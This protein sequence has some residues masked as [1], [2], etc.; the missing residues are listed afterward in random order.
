MQNLKG[1]PIGVD[2]KVNPSR[3]RP[4]LSYPPA[5]GS[6]R[7]TTQ[8]CLRYTRHVYPKVN[9]SRDR[10]TSSYPPPGD[11]LRSACHIAHSWQ[12]LHTSHHS[13][14]SAALQM[15]QLHV[16]QEDEH[17]TAA[18]PCKHAFSIQK[19][20]S[21]NLVAQKTTCNWFC[22]KQQIHSSICSSNPK[23]Q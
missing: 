3:D 20:H 7:Y 18:I 10:P 5:G 4:T 17:C 11:S 9:P 2:L 21:L 8:V 1:D 22:S 14:N 6:L 12:C 19:L 15:G 16:T 23:P 13:A